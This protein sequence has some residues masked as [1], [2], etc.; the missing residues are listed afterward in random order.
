[1]TRV[2][3]SSADLLSIARFDLAVVGLGLLAALVVTRNP[4][5][6]A[7]GIVG[8]AIVVG[9]CVALPRDYRFGS[10]IGLAVLAGLDVLP[11]PDLD[12]IV[13]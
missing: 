8:L 9:G 11:G 12:T 10:L 4:S 5:G 7:A 3:L 13:V 6:A 2:R 1:M